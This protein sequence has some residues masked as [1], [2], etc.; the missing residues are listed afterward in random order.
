[1][2]T[3]NLIAYFSWQVAISNKHKF[4]FRL[5]WKHLLDLNPKISN[6]C[7]EVKPW[8]G[9]AESPISIII[10]GWIHERLF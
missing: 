9:L 2:F 3:Y 10:C 8:W 4:C 1:M 6:I 5:F 7:G